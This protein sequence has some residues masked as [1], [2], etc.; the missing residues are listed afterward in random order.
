[1][2]IG[3]KKFIF[4]P[5]ITYRIIASQ[6]KRVSLLII[7]ANIIVIISVSMISKYVFYQ[8]FYGNVQSLI[9]SLDINKVGV[10]YSSEDI[11]KLSNIIQDHERR[12]AQKDRPNLLYMRSDLGIIAKAVY[13]RD[14]YM[15]KVRM[16]YLTMESF[17]D[18]KLDQRYNLIDVDAPASFP[19]DNEII[20]YFNIE[21]LSLS[22]RHFIDLP[23]EKENLVY[24]FDHISQDGVYLR[25]NGW[26]FIDGQSSRGQETYVVLQSNNS[27]F[28]YDTSVDYRSDVSTH[29]GRNDLDDA[30]FIATIRKSDI[31]KGI[32]RVGLYIK[33]N[34]IYGHVFLD[35]KGK[36]KID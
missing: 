13:G 21:K 17:Y 15:T 27:R 10:Q 14:V 6:K 33:G 7:T 36:I 24:F 5:F 28:I 30:G 31:G 12:F 20:K 2:Q 11:K 34:D 29:F 26:A 3:E 23:G 16:P 18:R 8:A 22:K 19:K 4:I 35:D 25:I 32:F 9:S 1:M